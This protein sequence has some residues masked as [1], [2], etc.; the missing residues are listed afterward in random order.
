MFPRTS[1]AWQPRT[2][3]FRE[4]EP[5]SDV[6]LARELLATQHAAYAVEAGLIQDD[7]I[8]P[9][10]EDIHDLCSASLRWLGAFVG[11]RLVG[12]VAWVE[13]LDEYQIDRLIVIPKAHRGGGGAALVREVL[14]RAG[15]T[16]A[17]VSTGRD[18]IPARALYERLGFSRVG[19][20]EVIPGLWVTD[21]A[22]R[23][24]F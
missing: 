24:G 12:A 5:A 1:A 8:P 11:D 23:V 19:D 22:R 6:E 14:I 7:R 20:R 16:C 17:V 4:L 15:S 9:L 18:N 10:H 13:G 3:L 2:V 21:Y